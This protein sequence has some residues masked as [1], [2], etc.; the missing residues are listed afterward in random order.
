MNIKFQRCTILHKEGSPGACLYYTYNKGLKGYFIN[1]LAANNTVSDKI[2]LA[3][4]FTYFLK[5]IVTGMD[6]YISPFD[7]LLKH[8]IVDDFVTDKKTD[9][10]G[11][12]IF[13]LKPYNDKVAESVAQYIEAQKLKEVANG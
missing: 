6:V 7:Y 4:I 11:K 10:E 2:A 3:D 9:Y 5:E 12:T 8:P 1:S 13:K